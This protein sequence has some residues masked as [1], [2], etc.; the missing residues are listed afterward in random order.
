MK[1]FE[2]NMRKTSVVSAQ[3]FRRNRTSSR[4]LPLPDSESLIS[5]DGV[6]AAKDRTG[7]RFLHERRRHEAD[8]VGSIYQTSRALWP[9]I[10]A[11]WSVEE[12]LAVLGNI[13]SNGEHSGRCGQQ[14]VPRSTVK[15][16][17]RRRGT[18]AIFYHTYE[19]S[20]IA[21][22]DRILDFASS[23]EIELCR[24]S[25]NAMK[26]R[27]VSHIV[28]RAG[29]SSLKAAVFVLQNTRHMTEFECLF[30]QR[31]RHDLAEKCLS[32]SLITGPHEVLNR[33]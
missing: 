32:V 18:A 33:Q 22:D 4:L 9:D 2:R 29:C 12:Y 8:A 7:E 20:P 16:M 6:V 1:R 21:A 28:D 26:D 27:L 19:T 25:I 3:L 24:E 5:R 30:L 31:I 14:A 10:S 23:C 17:S 15:S 11:V 13:K